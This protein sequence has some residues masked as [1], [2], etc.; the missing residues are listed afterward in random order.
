MILFTTIG[1]WTV[2]SVFAL[3]WGL[4]L[5]YRWN[6]LMKEY[7]PLGGAWYC[8]G[9]GVIGFFMPFMTIII[10]IGIEIAKAFFKN[11]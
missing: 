6:S 2:G 3:M 7:K 9:V 4:Y 1:V 5:A 8:L 11:K 10:Y